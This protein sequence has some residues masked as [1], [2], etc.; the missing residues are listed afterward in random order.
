MTGIMDT[1]PVGHFTY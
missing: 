1:S